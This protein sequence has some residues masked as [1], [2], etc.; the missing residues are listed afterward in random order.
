MRFSQDEFGSLDPIQLFEICASDREN[1]EAWTEFLRRYSVKL[2]YFIRGTLRQSMGCS[3]YLN[4]TI[5]SGGMQ[6]SDLFQNAI[7]RLVEH[8][9]AAM[10]RFS[11]TTE[12]ELLTYLAV[13]CRSSVLDVFRRQHAHKRRP[14][15]S[16]KDESLMDSRST[17]RLINHTGFERDILAR[18]LM[19][20]TQHTL[21]SQSS[22]VSNRDQ[23]V[24]ELHFFDGLSC[25]QI[26]QC[27][28]VN[29]SKSGVE[30]LIKR[31]VGQIQLLASPEKSGE[32]LQ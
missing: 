18:E 22:Q 20:L 24:F 10:K 2:K 31:L 8:D 23:L 19:F 1:S 32:T 15:T 28:G 11:G 26:A 25:R 14:I 3:V 12:Q 17:H 16:N 6:E 27:R 9:C 13:I 29:L 5:P 7:I 30:K 21:K 4:S